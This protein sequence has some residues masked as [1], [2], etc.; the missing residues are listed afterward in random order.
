MPTSTAPEFGIQDVWRSNLEE[1]FRKIRQ[2]VNSYPYV[3]MVSSVK[4][5]KSDNSHD[6]MINR[7]MYKKI[8]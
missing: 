4:S 8:Y 5:E 6:D 3:A 7:Q 1:E 2:V